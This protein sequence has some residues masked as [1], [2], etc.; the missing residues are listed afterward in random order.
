[1]FLEFFCS[2]LNVLAPDTVS[3]TLVSA[4][5]PELAVARARAGVE[6][7]HLVTRDAKEK[8][9]VLDS[10]P[11]QITQTCNAERI[12]CTMWRECHRKARRGAFTKSACLPRSTASET[13]RE[14]KI[15]EKLSPGKSMNILIKNHWLGRTFCFYYDLFSLPVPQFFLP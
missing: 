7:S 3:C 13:L 9:G 10:R 4:Q 2:E 5:S 15:F 8:W 11:F 14:E 1:M 6:S 12:S